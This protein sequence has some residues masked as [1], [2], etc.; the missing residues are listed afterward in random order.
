VSRLPVTAVLKFLTGILLVQ[1][2]TAVQLILAL[3]SQQPEIWLMLAVF[4]VTTGFL[5][6]LWFS[7]IAGHAAR[8]TLSDAEER[9]SRERERIVARAEQEKAKVIARERRRMQAKAGLKVGGSIAAVVG[10]G[11]LMLLTQFAGVGF[12]ILASGGGAVG[13]YLFRARQEQ[14]RHAQGESL[15]SPGGREKGRLVGEDAGQASGL[16]PRKGTD[17]K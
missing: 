10:L 4:A 6:A 9:L 12:L 15:E 13:G 11:V 5:A 7:S 2:F 1:T 14:H 3:H 8:E 17:A 16:L